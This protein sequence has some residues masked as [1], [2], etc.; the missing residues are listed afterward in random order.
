ME[1][2]TY[3]VVSAGDRHWAVKKVGTKSAVYPTQGEAIK[4]ATKLA[5][6]ECE[7]QVVVVQPSA[8]SNK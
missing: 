1:N 6:G 7:A 8:V 4:A 2:K 5:R 3:H